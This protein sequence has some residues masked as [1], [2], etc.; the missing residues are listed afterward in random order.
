M[1][2]CAVLL[3]PRTLRVAEIRIAEINIHI[4]AYQFINFFIHN[5]SR[6]QL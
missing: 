2:A 6:E 1:L 3:I 5:L 4:C